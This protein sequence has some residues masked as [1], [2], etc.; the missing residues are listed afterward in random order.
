MSSEYADACTRFLQKLVSTPSPP[1]QEADVAQLIVEE[2]QALGFRE[3]F[4]DEVGNVVGKL[5]RDEGPI[6]LVDSHMDTAAVGDPSA[7]EVDP[8]GAEIQGD[9]LFGL[10]SVDAKG[11]LAAMLY[12]LGLLARSQPALKGQVWV[13]VVVQEEPAEG[14]ALQATLERMN[15]QPD[16][17]VIAKPTDMRLV[18]G[19]RGRMEIRLATYGR[20][21]HSAM[22]EQGE[23]ALYAAARLVFGIELLGMGL[24]TDPVLGQ[25]TIAI[26]R[27]TSQS[28]AR[29]AIPDRCDLVI[30]RRVTLGETTSRVLAE[31]EA[32]IQ[33]EGVR[34]DV[35]IAHYQQPTYTGYK[36]AADASFPAWLL[37]EDH[38]LLVQAAAS[39]ERNLGRKPEVGIWR[40]SSDGVYTMGLAGIPTIGFGPGRSLLSHA[41]NEFILLSDVHRSIPIYADLARDLL[42]GLDK[43]RTASPSSS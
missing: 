32:L 6:L 36:L 1:G 10:G 24:M 35:R 33:R 37:P 18:R 43:L 12:G 31:L 30:D 7:W 2:M 29:N 34:A 28:S 3:A 39:L 15:L 13:T 14:L 42:Y 4:V 16:W 11:S 23:N 19:H 26:T 25:G 5:G 20:T 22:P 41:P 21:A 9:R 8:F 27:F 40:F 38:P 17:V